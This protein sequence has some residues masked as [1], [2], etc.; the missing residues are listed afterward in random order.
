MNSKKLILGWD[1][2]D[3]YYS[4]INTIISYSGKH[5]KIPLFEQHLSLSLRCPR[6]F[7]F[8]RL[9]VEEMLELFL[10]LL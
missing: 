4:I 7:P 2:V 10:F 5:N 8:K 6:K 3:V 9:G 1:W